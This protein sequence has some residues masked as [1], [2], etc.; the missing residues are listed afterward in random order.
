[1]IENCTR[2]YRG[3]MYDERAE[4]LF[5]P[6]VTSHLLGMFELNCLGVTVESPVED[7]ADELRAAL[8]RAAGAAP[9]ERT[10]QL[11]H[12]KALL[13]LLGTSDM[14]CEVPPLAT[15]ATASAGVP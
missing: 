14:P 11:R 2:L 6:A 5:E 1:M 13:G 8:K 9:S 7:V 15:A 3:C 12:T 4:A 10:V